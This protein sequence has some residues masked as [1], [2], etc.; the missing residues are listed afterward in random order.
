MLHFC[1]YIFPIKCEHCLVPVS[2]NLKRQKMFQEKRQLAETKITFYSTFSKE[3]N[4]GTGSANISLFLFLSLSHS[5]TLSLS[6]SLSL[7]L[8]RSIFSGVKWNSF[9]VIILL[10]ID[11]NLSEKNFKEKR[12]G[13]KNDENRVN[14]IFEGLCQRFI[15]T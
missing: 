10:E 1:N 6:L 5:L 7:S 3:R 13:L 11:Q 2:L 12:R 8:Q 15:S 4:C 14:R 9:A